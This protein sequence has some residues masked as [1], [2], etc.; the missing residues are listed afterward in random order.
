VAREWD[1]VGRRM[2]SSYRPIDLNA[3]SPGCGTV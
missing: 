2:A 1:V 3:W